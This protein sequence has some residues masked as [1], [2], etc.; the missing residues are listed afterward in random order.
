MKQSVSYIVPTLHS[1]WERRP[2]HTHHKHTLQTQQPNP[3]NS[4]PLLFVFLLSIIFR[5]S[6]FALRLALHPN[7]IPSTIINRPTDRLT[8]LGQLALQQRR[9]AQKSVVLLHR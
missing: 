3:T 6:S 5:S 1:L 8:R 2:C 9:S 4:L 7:T